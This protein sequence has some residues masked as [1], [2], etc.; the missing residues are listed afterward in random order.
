MGLEMKIYYSKFAKDH[1]HENPIKKH[2]ESINMYLVAC[3][4]GLNVISDL[5]FRFSFK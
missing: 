2:F 4:Y 5:S 3:T 1:F